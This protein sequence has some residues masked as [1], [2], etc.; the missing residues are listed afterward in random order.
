MGEGDVDSALEST[1]Q[2]KHERSNPITN[3]TDIFRSH[4]GAV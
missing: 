2:I 1:T 3:R 4:K